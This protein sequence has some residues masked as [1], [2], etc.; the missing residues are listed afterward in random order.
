MRTG[1]LI[2]LLLVSAIMLCIA[3]IFV[4]MYNSAA[5]Y[6]TIEEL[7]TNPVNTHRLMRVKGELTRDSVIFTQHVPLLEFT[8]T[9]GTHQLD[10]VYGRPA[11]D[12]FL[13]ANEVI[14]EGRLSEQGVFTVSKLMLQCPSK[15][16]PDDKGV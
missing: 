12:N 10:A 2:T 3:G 9:D 4:T 1:T 8:L 15:Y 7:V 14:V 6:Y 11:P 13:H 16:E 5:Y